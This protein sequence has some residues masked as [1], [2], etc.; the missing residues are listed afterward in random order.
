[1]RRTSW[2]TTVGAA[3]AVALAWSASGLAAENVPVSSDAAAHPNQFCVGKSSDCSHPGTRF[4]FRI[5]TPA[6]VRIDARPRSGQYRYGFVELVRHFSAGAHSVRIN[7]TRMKPGRWEIRVQGTNS[8]GHGTLAR[9]VV[10]V[11]K[12]D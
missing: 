5:S 3:L 2:T 8:V 12:H 10:R 9:V 6:K 4:S 11:V 1:M 7:D